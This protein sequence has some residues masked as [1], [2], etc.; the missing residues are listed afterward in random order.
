MFTSKSS[1]ILY[2]MTTRYRRKMEVNE[3]ILAKTYVIGW[4]P[5]SDDGC[6]SRT[7]EVFVTS[8]TMRGPIGLDGFPST[9]TST[10]ASSDPTSL[11]TTSLYN[12][13]CFRCASGTLTVVSLWLNTSLKMSSSSMGWEQMTSQNQTGIYW[14]D[15]TVLI[16]KDIF[17]WISICYVE[18]HL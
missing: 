14:I 8:L 16:W 6:H 4:P 9:T 17:L 2:A 15:S 5:S 1:F 11:E 18:L 12:A 7:A 3:R 10:T 13:V